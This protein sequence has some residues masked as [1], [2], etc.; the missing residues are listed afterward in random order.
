M[1][2]YKYEFQT[3]KEYDDGQAGRPTKVETF[4]DCAH[5]V[6]VGSRTSVLR[7]AE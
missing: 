5:G 2:Q 6:G 3:S 1:M 4:V 7:E